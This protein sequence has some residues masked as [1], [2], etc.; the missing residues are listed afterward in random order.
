MAHPEISNPEDRAGRGHARG[1]QQLLQAAG[2]AAERRGLRRANVD[3]EQGD[4][5]V[6]QPLAPDVRGREVPKGGW[7]R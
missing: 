5:A 3:E 4:A 7:R 2:V 1:A 6:D